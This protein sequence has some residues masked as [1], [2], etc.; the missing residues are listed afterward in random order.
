MKY[1]VLLGPIQLTSNTQA[2]EGEIIDLPESDGSQLVRWGHV[3]EF[4][5]PKTAKSADTKENEADK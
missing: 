3:E 5:P 2:H 4:K 1:K